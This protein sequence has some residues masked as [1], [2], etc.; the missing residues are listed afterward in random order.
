MLLHGSVKCCL[1]VN[2]AGNRINS[3]ANLSLR[4]MSRDLGDLP[5]HWRSREN[6]HAASSH[7]AGNPLLRLIRE[8]GQVW[9]NGKFWDLATALDGFPKHLWPSY[10][11]QGRGCAVWFLSSTQ[12]GATSITTFITGHC[13]HYRARAV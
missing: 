4:S 2:L 3:R 7:Q 1:C 5:V 8:F 13:C 6:N 9:L 11:C 10:K 12:D